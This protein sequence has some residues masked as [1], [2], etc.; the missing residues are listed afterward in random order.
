MIQVVGV[1][2]SSRRPRFNPR[3]FHAGFGME[4]VV[5]EE[6]FLKVLLFSLSVIPPIFHTHSSTTYTT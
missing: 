1:G 2:L 5:W 3:Q 4:K 6:V